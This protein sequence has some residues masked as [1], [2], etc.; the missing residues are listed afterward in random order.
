MVVAKLAE[1]QV[2]IHAVR[3]P[4]DV[5]AVVSD[6]RATISAMEKLDSGLAIDADSRQWVEQLRTKHPKHDRAVARLHEMLLRVAHHELSRRRGQL[7][8]VSGPE[9]DDLAHQAA[10]D[11]LVNVL[12]R[13]DEFR[14]LSRFTTWAYKFAVFEVSSKVGRHAWR[15]QPPGAAELSWDRLPDSMAPRPGDRLEQRERLAALSGAIGELTERQREVFVAIALNDVSIDV[16]AIQLGSNRNAIYKNLFDARRN[17]RVKM[18]AA[19]HPVL[20]M[21]AA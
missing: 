17:L 21:D 9:F 13:L 3:D 1:T 11:A 7:Q 5:D 2:A 4:A 14:G 6:S 15:R 18:A 12:A 10:D 20:D 8:S 16:L 19:G